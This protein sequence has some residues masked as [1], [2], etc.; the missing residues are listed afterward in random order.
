MRYPY[1]TMPMIQETDYAY[2]AGLIDGDGCVLV[3]RR[4]RNK[5]STGDRRRGPSF[6]INVKIGGETKHIYGLREKHEN[7]GSVYTRKGKRK[8]HLAEWTIA[9]KR[10]RA[11]LEK[12]V[13]HMI[14]KKPQGLLVLQMP[15]P[16]SR[17]GVT[18]E[19]RAEQERIR[20]EIKR[21]NKL[22]RGK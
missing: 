7:I 3:R 6:S 5:E 15:W 17:W 10:G 16:G 2:L 9:A 4:D 18:P 21:L 22:G 13:P 14:L 8:R 12:V 11:L 20:L 19:L 1:Y